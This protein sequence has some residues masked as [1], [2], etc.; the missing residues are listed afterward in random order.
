MAEENKMNNNEGRMPLVLP[1]GRK[2]ILRPYDAYTA[3]AI[4]DTALEEEGTSLDKAVCG[5]I[6]ALD[7]KALPRFEDDRGPAI[8]AA[9]DLLL[10]DYHYIIFMAVASFRDGVFDGEVPDGKG[11]TFNGHMELLDNEGKA[12]KH[13]QPPPYPL[14]TA[15]TH[16]WEEEV[17]E[18]G[19]KLVNFKLTL[20]DGKARASMIEDEAPNLNITLLSRNP[21]YHDPQKDMLIK[22]D[23]KARLNSPSWAARI[24]TRKAKEID[25][26]IQFSGL[27]K[28]KGQSV[29]RSFFQIPDFFLRDFT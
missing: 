19:G 10:N 8:S 2:A 14:G 13:F 20:L 9:R 1:S 18:L 7:G 3:D 28:N 16:E 17:P 5:L 27:F 4:G 21:A 23:P 11:G 25:P 22:Y 29:N 12:L 6:E 24:L 15:K 26:V